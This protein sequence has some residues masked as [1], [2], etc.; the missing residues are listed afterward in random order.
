M[1]STELEKM[2]VM[3][4]IQTVTFLMLPV[5]ILKEKEILQKVKTIHEEIF[6]QRSDRITALLLDIKGLFREIKTIEAFIIISLSTLSTL[7][8]ENMM[9]STSQGSCE[10]ENLIKEINRRIEAVEE[11]TKTIEKRIQEI[12]ALY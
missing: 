1:N 7:S 11:R 4:K 9:Q 12:E 10:G 2:N 5:F 8:S 6:S 3:Y